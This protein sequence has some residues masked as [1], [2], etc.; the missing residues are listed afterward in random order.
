MA[1]FIKFLWFL[2]SRL[3][4]MMMSNQKTRGLD[5]FMAAGAASKIYIQSGLKIIF[6]TFKNNSSFE[7]LGSPWLVWWNFE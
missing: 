6:R 5:K 7:Q 1:G 4:E 3:Q 2:Y